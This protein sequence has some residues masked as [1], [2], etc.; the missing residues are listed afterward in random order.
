[1][2]II[3]LSFITSNFADPQFI[4]PPE[5]V[6]T[7][8]KYQ[9][10]WTVSEI[11]I[12]WPKKNSLVQEVGL[13]CSK[14]N[15]VCWSTNSHDSSAMIGLPTVIQNISHNCLQFR[16]YV[17]NV[18][19]CHVT[20]KPEVDTTTLYCC[21]TSEIASVFV[22][23]GISLQRVWT[24]CL[25]NNLIRQC[26]GLKVNIPKVYCSISYAKLSESLVTIILD[27][28]TGTGKIPMHPQV[29]KHLMLNIK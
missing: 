23:I 4:I 9:M 19:D 7:H 12:C 18:G 11:H 14:T 15:T 24:F 6:V 10:D 28:G 27:E 13:I 2:H 20:S 21:I 26:L 29:H 5:S 8:T 1:M 25:G 3:L 17:K 22:I 16:T